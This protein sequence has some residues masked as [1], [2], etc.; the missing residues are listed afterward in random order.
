MTWTFDKLGDLDFGQLVYSHYWETCVLKN[1]THAFMAESIS[2]L[3]SLH[4]EADHISAH[5]VVKV[6]VVVV[7]P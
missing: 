7:V 3:F 6:I 1:L 4:F 5:A 2:G